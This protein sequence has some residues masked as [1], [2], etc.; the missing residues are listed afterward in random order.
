MDCMKKTLT[1]EEIRRTFAQ[2]VELF[3]SSDSP[4]GRRATTSWLELF[5]TTMIVLDVACGAAYATEQ[6]APRVRQVVGL[7]LTPDLLA[8]GDARLR[9]AG[10]SNV[11]LLEGNAAALPFVDAS[12]DVVFC[13]SALHHFR[14][15]RAIVQEMARVC[16]SQ[17]RV[18]VMDMVAPS[19]DV[20]GAFDALHRLMDPSH[21]EVLLSDEMVGLLAHPGFHSIRP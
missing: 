18:V 15:P 16:R 2:L 10:V 20:R 21:M 19:P 3:S 11:L 4:F 6:I 12:F 17:G 7:D 14:S 13:R 5:E 8:V 1:D 9:D